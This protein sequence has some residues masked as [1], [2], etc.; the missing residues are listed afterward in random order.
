[1][2]SL[3]DLNLPRDLWAVNISAYIYINNLIVAK[4]PK[5]LLLKFEF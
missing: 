1:M 2:S 4:L 3:L 5:P